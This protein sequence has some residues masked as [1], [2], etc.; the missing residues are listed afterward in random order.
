MREEDGSTSNS[1][2]PTPKQ[3][4][5]RPSRVERRTQF[6]VRPELVEGRTQNSGDARFLGVGHWKLGVRKRV[7]HWELGV[8][9]WEFSR[10]LGVAAALVLAAAAVLDRAET[11]VRAC[12]WAPEFTLFTSPSDPDSQEF[13]SGNLG[14][15]LPGYRLRYLVVAW[16][17]LNGRYLTT[18]ERSASSF[19]PLPD[20]P[21]YY[22]RPRPAPPDPAQAWLD[23]RRT[24][25]QDILPYSGRQEALIEQPFMY[26]VNCNDDA[27]TNA[28]ETLE[29]RRKT[30]G[31]SSPEFRSWVLAQDVV[32]ANCE[33]DKR[34]GPQIP[35]P[36][37]E[38][39][40]PALRADRDYQ[41]AAALF[42]SGHFSM[43]ERAFDAIARDPGSPWR[44]LGP[45]LAARA[46]LRKATIG[47]DNAANP[48]E[49]ARARGRLAAIAVD[50]AQRD[51]HEPAERLMHY[52]DVRVHPAD[53]LAIVAH[54]LVTGDTNP[55]RFEQNLIDFTQLLDRADKDTSGYRSTPPDAAADDLVGWVRT[56]T[57]RTEPSHALERWRATHTQAWLLASIATTSPED[58]AVPELLEAARNLDPVAAAFP[59]I[60]FHRARLLLLRGSTDEA[61]AVLDDAL[62]TPRL[63]SSAVNQFRSARI[64]TARSLDEF[65]RD[66]ARTPVANWI[67]GDVGF[68]VTGHPREPASYDRDAIGVIN[69]RLPLSVM[70]RISLNPLT[71]SVMRLQVANAAFTRA[72]LMGDASLIRSSIPETARAIPLLASSLR[73]LSAAPDDASL[74]DEAWLLILAR[75]GL[76]PY[77]AAGGTRD[78]VDLEALDEFRD[79]WWCSVWPDQDRQPNALPP[80]AFL[81]ADERQAARDEAVRLQPLNATANELVG[82]AIDWADRHRDDPRAP[83]VLARAVRAGHLGCGDETTWPLSRKAFT[84]LHE[85]YPKSEWAGRTPYW[86]K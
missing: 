48:A 63:S 3:S 51:M 71:P 7:L 34:K 4:S 15:L 14:I 84:M 6:S 23:V 17:T 38:T 22:M 57:G 50:P 43:A 46:V 53:A 33:R 26:F 62:H 21:S 10:K 77:V 27:F 11:P 1:Q 9:S 25:G 64:Q 20:N 28:R 12:G 49:F 35:E 2:L 44:R 65:L 37:P 66:A 56:F 79:N 8:G 80:T 81:T 76:R 85:R 72:V 40:S 78:P 58:Q 55:E 82:R 39:A 47:D 74:M 60:A 83:R 52:I 18:A 69:E 13:L 68:V 19:A 86:Y 59:T 45:Y 67:D 42:Y 70:R 16:R 73:Q 41:I 29:S 36:L 32:F 31:A 30:L 5:V 61:R 75:P 54:D 24:V